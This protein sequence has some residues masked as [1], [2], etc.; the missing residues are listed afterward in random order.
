M[1]IT[2]S[3]YKDGTLQ[4]A[5]SNGYDIIQLKYDGHFCYCIS[6]NGVQDYFSDT[7]R[8]FATGSDGAPNGIFVGEFMRGTQWSKHP[9]RHGRFYIHDMLERDG[10]VLR[11][12]YVLRYRLF[13]SLADRLPPH[14][15]AVQNYRIQTRE[16][17]WQ[18]FVVGQ[19]FEGLVY[20]KSS[21]LPGQEL[22]REKAIFTLDGPIMA[23]NPGEGKHEGRM[24][25]VEV[26]VNGT[27]VVVGNG[28]SDEDRT[29]IY[30]QPH[31]YIGRHLELATNAIFTS[32][33]VRHA[34]FVRWRPD[35]DVT[36]SELLK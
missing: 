15:K 13:R 2:R 16:A 26:L 21:G 25:S 35:K 19:S 11:D 6:S 34:R 17:V 24:G 14:W 36:S 23:V 8:L 20:H 12:S 9:D 30:A 5:L 27:Q 22:I 1:N 10:T 32:G 7:G 33:N 31:L 29:L 3:K 18:E 4:D 28:W